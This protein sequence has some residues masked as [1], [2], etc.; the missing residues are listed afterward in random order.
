AS[1]AM[2]LSSLFVVSNAL[3]LNFFKAKKANPNYPPA[4]MPANNTQPSKEISMK[5]VELSIEGMMCMHCVGHVTKALNAIEGVT[6]EVSLENKNAV[7]QVADGVSTDTLTAAVVDAGY[8]V[9]AV[10]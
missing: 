8:Q 10:K 1:A 6:A 2:G 9:V 7:C 5:T 3:R 4:S